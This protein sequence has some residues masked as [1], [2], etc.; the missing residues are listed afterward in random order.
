MAKFIQEGERMQRILV[1][2][3]TSLCLIFLGSLLPSQLVI[4]R[5]IVFLGA[6]TLSVATI[7]MVF[8]GIYKDKVNWLRLSISIIIAL[9]AL[10]FILSLFVKIASI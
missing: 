2:L 7:W 9:L 1:V 8:R 5:S 6:M 4:L 10:S 3:T